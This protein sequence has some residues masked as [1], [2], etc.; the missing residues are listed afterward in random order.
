MRPALIIL[1]VA[2]ITLAIW[3]TSLQNPSDT[4]PVRYSAQFDESIP[5][6]LHVLEVDLTHPGIYFRS[7]LSSDNNRQI[8]PGLERL[9]AMAS[10]FEEENYRIGGVNA[11]F[12]SFD[13]GYP[14]NLH[15]GD[16][17]PA[18]PGLN[19][20]VFGKTSTDSLFISPI[21]FEAKLEFDGTSESINRINPLFRSDEPVMY[22]PYF[23][24]PI[25]TD[26]TGLA[27]GFSHLG[28]G[29]FRQETEKWLEGEIASD[30]FDL[31]VT[32]PDHHFDPDEVRITLHYNPLRHPIAQ[33]VGGGP[34]LIAGGELIVDAAAESE[35]IGSDFVNTRHPR[36]AVGFNAGQTKLYLVTAD[37]RSE[38][39]AGMNLYELG[40]FMISI[41][42]DHALNLDGGGSTTLIWDGAI[43][44][45]PSD[46]DGERAIA[47][48]LLIFR[49]D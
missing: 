25:H 33:A 18:T 8:L 13:S 41:G 19:R 49:K 37:G 17:I 36:T 2:A 7:V 31:V 22:T 5:C 4:N 44:N 21:E 34:Q 42:A 26:T 9:T 12:F 45:N 28:D 10:G 27:I 15:I 32:Y 6:S 11:D 48:G 35:G 40:E 46:D 43:K 24:K 3:A 20:S 23:G 47:N 29:R 1:L 14:V 38:E 39:S 16:F 30:T